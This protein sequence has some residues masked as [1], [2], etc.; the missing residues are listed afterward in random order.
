[1]STEFVSGHVSSPR[2]NQENEVLLLAMC[3]VRQKFYLERLTFIERHLDVINHVSFY[4]PQESKHFLNLVLSAHPISKRNL[5][6]ALWLK[7]LKC[8]GEFFFFVT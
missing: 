8:L 4:K 2:V 1:M 6:L 7:T 3:T 5:Y